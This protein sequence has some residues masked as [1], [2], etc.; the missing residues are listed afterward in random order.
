MARLAAAVPE[1]ASLRIPPPLPAVLG[2]RYVS[3]L[4]DRWIA[5]AFVAHDR[6]ANPAGLVQGGIVGSAMDVVYGTLGM[7]ILKR[8]CVT[9]TL[10]TAYH[11]PLAA[12]EREYEVTAHLVGKTRRLVYM[13][14]EAVSADGVKVATSNSTMAAVSGAK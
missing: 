7:T 9:L 13:R 12:D 2:M 4:P 1:G 6:F 8:P 5:C 11:K 14:A 3:W 10:D